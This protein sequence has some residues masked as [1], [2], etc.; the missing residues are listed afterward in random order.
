MNFLAG[1]AKQRKARFLPHS[2]E[3]SQENGSFWRPKQVMETKKFLRGNSFGV[4]KYKDRRATSGTRSS[5][6]ER[7]GC[8]GCVGLC[9]T[10]F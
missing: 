9:L 7:N 8:S 6:Y 10:W 5:M 4:I 3:V 1:G 2:V